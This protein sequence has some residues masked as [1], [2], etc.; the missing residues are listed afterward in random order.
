MNVYVLFSSLLSLY[1]KD[2]GSVKTNWELGKKTM[3]FFESLRRGRRNDPPIDTGP[4]NE[5]DS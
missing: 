2:C 4:E 5:F 3:L 1:K